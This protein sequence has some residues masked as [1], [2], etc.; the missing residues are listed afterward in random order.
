MENKQKINLH[1]VATVWRHWKPTFMRN[2]I[3]VFATF[4]FFSG[5]SYLDLMLK[6]T[7]WK[8]AFDELAR[9]GDPWPAF[10]III[11]LGCLGWLSARIGEVAIVLSESKIIKEL[12]DY[13][14][15]E[16]M[17]KS[18]H[19]FSTHSSG[20]LVAKAKRFAGVSERVID[21]FIFSN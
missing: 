7:Q 15:K 13:A 20:G 5:Q 3:G 17:G 18:T 21:E 14:L 6:P 1:V 12:K 10:K 11:L 16:L 8:I 19:F 9:G 2:G 4:L